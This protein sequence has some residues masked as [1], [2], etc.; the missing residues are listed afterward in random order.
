MKLKFLTEPNLDGLEIE[1]SYN[2]INAFRET[3][4]SKTSFKDLI[5]DRFFTQR[6]GIIKHKDE[7]FLLLESSMMY[8]LENELKKLKG[9]DKILFDISFKCGNDLFK[10]ENITNKEKFVTDFFGALGFG[11]VLVLRN[12]K[13]YSIIICYFP[14]TKWADKIDFTMIRG[15]ISGILSTDRKVILKKVEKDL[16]KGFFKNKRLFGFSNLYSLIGNLHFANFFVVVRPS[17][18]PNL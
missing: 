8:I 6:T 15:L 11:D 7:R 14:W 13:K 9:A 4:Y 5:D 1:N 18:L 17:H 16:S 2:N 10:K 3:E 12:N